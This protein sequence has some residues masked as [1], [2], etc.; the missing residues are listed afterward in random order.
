LERTQTDRAPVREPLDDRRALARFAEHAIV[1]E[2]DVVQFQQ[3][4][5]VPVDD[6]L[7][8]DHHSGIFRSDKEHSQSGR[9]FRG[10]QKQ[11]RDRPGLHRDF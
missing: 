2:N 7:P 3:S 11:I 6:L 9:G 8:P 5:G 1:A 4:F 10:H